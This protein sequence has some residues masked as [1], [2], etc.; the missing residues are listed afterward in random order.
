MPI[1]FDAVLLVG[2][3]IV[4]AGCSSVYADLEK[5]T[6][7]PGNTAWQPVSKT[8]NGAEMVEVR[9][10]CFMMGYE[11][12]RR[13]EQPVHQICFD[14]AFWIDRYEVSNGQYGSDGPFAGAN[15][16]HSNLTWFEARDFCAKRGARLPTEAEWE[17]AARGPDSLLYPWG[18]KF[19]P[20]NLVYDGNFNNQLAEIRSRPG[21][22]SWVGAYDL[23]GNA[24][25]WV[26]S[27]Y[28]PY[29]Y[30]ANP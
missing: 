10:V 11:K 1:R 6:Y 8:F 12:G 20:D 3:V 17:Y 15:K 25:V 14:K 13:D 5:P 7:V 19:V 29:P 18:D 27:L 21:A 4:C 26:T 2:V 24:W 9:T 23:A 28:P 16:P 22:D 30:N